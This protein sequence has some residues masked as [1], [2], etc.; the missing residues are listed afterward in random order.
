MNITPKFLHLN[1]ERRLDYSEYF[2]EQQDVCVGVRAECEQ[3]ED[4]VVLQVLQ[5][6]R[7]GWRGLI[8]E[9]GLRLERTQPRVTWIRLK[10]AL[11]QVL[12]YENQSILFENG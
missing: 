6:L 5:A 10:I 2:V 12:F 8:G 7:A 4:H 3:H 1:I 11:N 9:G